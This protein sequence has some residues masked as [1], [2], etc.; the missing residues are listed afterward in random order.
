MRP[1]TG[2]VHHVIFERAR[3]PLPRELV[4]DEVSSL[5]DGHLRPTK[6]DGPMQQLQCLAE[7]PT[8]RPS[9]HLAVRPLVQHSSPWSTPLTSPSSYVIRIPLPRTTIQGASCTFFISLKPVALVSGLNLN[10]PKTKIISLGDVPANCAK[11]LSK[12]NNRWKYISCDSWG[13]Y[14]GFATGLG[15]GH[16][17]GTSLSPLLIPA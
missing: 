9:S 1:S 14:L 7:H 15:K 5:C 4:F 6:G 8:P 17:Y 10:L 2:C 16:H 13:T 3:A 12:T 11:C